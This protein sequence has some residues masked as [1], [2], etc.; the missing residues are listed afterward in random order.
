MFPTPPPYAPSD[1]ITNPHSSSED[2]DDHDDY[3]PKDTFRVPDWA[4]SPE[5]R[6]QLQRQQTMNPEEVFG[7]MAR[8]DMEAIFT[9]RNERQLAR[10]RARTSSANWNG[11]DRLTP[12]E[13]AADHEA[14]L[15]M[16]EQGGWVYQPAP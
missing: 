5:L 15:R 2:E 6:A 8:L 1:A 9:N 3:A 13:I 14:R 10:F 12:A 4:E 16:I 7:P 11:A